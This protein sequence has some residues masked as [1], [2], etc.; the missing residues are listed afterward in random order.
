MFFICFYSCGVEQG[1]GWLWFGVVGEEDIM[2][3][4]LLSGW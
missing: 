2:I 4:R 3:G 1:K